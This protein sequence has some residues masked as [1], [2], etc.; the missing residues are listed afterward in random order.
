MAIK[1]VETWAAEVARYDFDNIARDTDLRNCI[2]KALAAAHAKDQF[3]FLIDKG[4]ATKKYEKYIKKANDL[5]ISAA[6]K[7]KCDEAAGDVKALKKLIDG[8]VKKEAELLIS[9][10]LPGILKKS[11]IFKTWVEQANRA[12]VAAKA[13]TSAAKAAK[14]L[15]ISDVEDFTKAYVALAT[16][17]K[18]LATKLFRA[19]EKAEHQKNLEA[20]VQKNLAASGLVA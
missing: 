9:T 8:E 7:K 15:G 11:P 6:L 1:S 10:N 12:A 19:I 16:G 18:A 20:M 14:L 17:E 4:D 5:N 13:K 3:D 2:S